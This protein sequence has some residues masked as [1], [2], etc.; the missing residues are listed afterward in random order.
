[1][2]VET[3][4]RYGRTVAHVKLPNGLALNEEL[5]RA[6]LAWHYKQYSSNNS[7]AKLESE[8]RAASLGVWS[9]RP[10]C[11]VGLETRFKEIRS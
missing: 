9:K 8:A 7:L 5:L 1:M 2:Q 3:I 4:D 6:G 10:G 11:T